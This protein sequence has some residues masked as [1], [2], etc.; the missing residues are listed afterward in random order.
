MGQIA[1]IISRIFHF[2]NFKQP[3]QF[4]FEIKSSRIALSARVIPIEK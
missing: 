2:L 4:K 1:L 3:P